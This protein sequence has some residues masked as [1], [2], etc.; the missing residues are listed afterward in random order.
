[1]IVLEDQK[2]LRKHVVAVRLNDKQLGSLERMAKEDNTTLSSV[3]VAMIDGFST[4]EKFSP[5]RETVLRAVRSHPNLVQAA[6]ALGLSRK[7]LYQRR[8]RLGLLRH[9]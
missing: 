4:I 2:N 5:E 1:M 9:S 8:K 6:C 7:G 3:L